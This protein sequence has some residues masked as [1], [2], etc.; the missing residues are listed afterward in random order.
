[1]LF[2]RH[3]NDDNIYINFILFI[4]KINI[5][6]GLQ[7]FINTKVLPLTFEKSISWMPFLILVASPL[8]YRGL[9][10]KSCR[11]GAEK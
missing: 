5:F 11:Q 2:Y 7:V 1:M 6:S 9:C 3:N 10:I 8:A 4:L